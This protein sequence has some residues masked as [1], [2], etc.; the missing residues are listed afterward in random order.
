MTAAE[1][2]DLTFHPTLLVGPVQP[3]LAEERVVAVVGPQRHEPGMLEP[4]PAQRD[5][6]HRRLQIVVADHPGRHPAER[7][8]RSDMPVQERL[9]GLVGVGEVERLARVRQPHTKHEQLHHLPGDRGGELAEVDLRLR[10]RRMGLRHHHLAPVAPIS[11]RS[12]ATIFRTVD[13][14]TRAPSSSI[15][16]CQIR[17]AVCRCFRGTVQILHQPTPDKINMRPSH[18]RRPGPGPSAPAGPRPPT[19]DAPSADAPDDASPAPGSTYP[20]RA[21]RVG[22]V[23]TAPLSISPS[24]PPPLGSP[25]QT[26]RK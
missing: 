6:D 24:H 2:A 23:R 8:E 12:R 15:S 4:F 18:R 11:T 10:R 26:S 13:S 25:W 16:R 22:Y 7:L 14:P 3:G 21:S 17:R 5:P 1:P 9:L 19:P 20:H